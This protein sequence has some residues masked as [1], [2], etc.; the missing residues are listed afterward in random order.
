MIKLCDS[1]YTKQLKH[2]ELKKLGVPLNLK[3]MAKNS[4]SIN[5]ITFTIHAQYF[6]FIEFSFANLVCLA[7][8]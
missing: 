1:H 2:S 7:W 3:W 6:V 5:C 4:I 8:Y